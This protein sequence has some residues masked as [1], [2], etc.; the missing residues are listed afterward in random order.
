M[1][2]EF[3]EYHSENGTIPYS[4]ST[5]CFCLTQYAKDYITENRKITSNIDK[6]IRDAVLV[7]AIN[8]L[9]VQ[10]YCDFAL[11]TQDLYDDKRHEEIVDPQCLLTAVVNHYA[12]YMFNQGIVESVLRNNHMNECTEQFDAN[13]GAI[14]L[15]DFI[16]YISKKNDYDKTFTIREIYEKFKRQ[17]HN[18]EM[19]ELKKFLELTSKYSL[20]LANGRSIDAIFESMAL[21]HNLKYVAEDGTYHYT[22]TIRDMVGQSQM[23]FWDAEEVD[24]EVYAMAYAYAK[25][26][27]DSMQSSQT[28]IINKKILEMR[29][30][31]YISI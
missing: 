9:G 23:Y 27:N 25:M 21:K 19:N 13:D 22:D 8:Y 10:S 20:E 14:V 16:N 31:Y 24:E 26:D 11:Y 18:G 5:L 7:D 6:K 1:G 3:I 15:L 30:R 12:Y 29:I 28:E 17:R 2:K 4:V